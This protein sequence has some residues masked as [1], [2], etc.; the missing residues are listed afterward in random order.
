MVVGVQR[1]GVALI[2]LAVVT[3]IFKKLPGLYLGN[4]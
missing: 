4:C 2:D 1:H 3:L